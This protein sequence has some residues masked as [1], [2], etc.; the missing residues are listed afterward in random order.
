[1]SSDST[2]ELPSA[3]QKILDNTPELPTAPPVVFKLMTLLKKQTQHNEE[4]VEIIRY[5][6]HLT[7]KLLKLCNAAFF[8]VGVCCFK[9]VYKT[10]L[11]VV[12]YSIPIPNI[13]IF[14]NG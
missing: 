10:E 1:M 6:E 2:I 4:I 12:K 11:F 7:A 9:S 5:D 13:N 14:V 8:T 3:V